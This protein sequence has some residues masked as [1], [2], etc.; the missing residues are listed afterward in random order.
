MLAWWQLWTAHFNPKTCDNLIEAGLK[1]KPQDG[2]IG[3]GGSAKSDQKMRRSKVRWVHR[4]TKGFE[5]I[6]HR[7]S[8][9]MHEANGN[10][11][12]FDLTTLKEMQFTE[13]RAEEE[14]H[15]DW[16]EDLCWK[17]QPPTM[18]QRKLS[19]VLQLSDSGT[20]DGGDFQV[21]HDQIAPKIVRPR[22]S[23]IVFPSFLRHR[24]TPLTRGVRYS[25][26]CWMPGPNFR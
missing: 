6:W 3:F 26:V 12:G 10:A 8:D 15:Y 20:Y 24:V 21:A 1:I 19:L 16:H 14:G 13:Y 17:P 11:F 18:S 9:M 2:V 5:H 4:N 23:V 7:L 25:L 22:G